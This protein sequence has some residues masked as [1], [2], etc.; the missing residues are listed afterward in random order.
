[1]ASERQ[2]FVSMDIL[3][4]AADLG[5]LGDYDIRQ[6]PSARLAGKEQCLG[7]MPWIDRVTAIKP[8]GAI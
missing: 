2:A 8:G 1:M 3:H 7:D 5:L 4:A 6:K